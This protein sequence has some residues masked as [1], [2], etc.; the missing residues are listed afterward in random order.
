MSQ[1]VVTVPALVLACV[2][3]GLLTRLPAQTI[4]QPTPL[5]TTPESVTPTLPAKAQRP[6]LMIKQGGL[7]LE[8]R[9]SYSHSS[10]NS[11]YI[12]GVSVYPILVIGE[13]GVERVRKDS[14]VTSLSGRYGVRNNLMAE[15]KLPV[16]FRP[17][18]YSVPDVSPPQE[19]SVSN[20]GIGDIEGGLFYQ[21]PRQ[22]EDHTRWVASINVKST[23][24]QD[25]FEINI[26][27][28]VPLGSGFWNTKVGITSVKI[29][30]PAA[31]FWNAGYTVNWERHD[32]P[33]TVTDMQTGEESI[34]YLDIKPAN[35]VEMGGGFAYAINPRLSVNTGVSISWSGSCLSEGKKVPN[36]AFT[37]ATLR[38]GAVWL[39]D[40]NLPV[41]IGLGIG[42]TDDSPD[43]SL[44]FRHNFKL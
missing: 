26:K 9:T 27:K 18:R 33:I 31:V 14:I 22:H 16:S 32:I 3:C 23:T 25:P 13:V 44:D 43:F 1:S 11:V 5:A 37:T 24:G 19:H 38:L 42:L 40:N 2:L 36:S 12:D 34:L 30:D 15:I 6:S 4:G 29:S 10:R 28:S 35:L 8:W 39:T 20:F 7:E 21:L 17:E 41:D